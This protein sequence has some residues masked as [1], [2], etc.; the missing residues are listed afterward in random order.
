MF[1]FIDRTTA[2][3]IQNNHHNI[4]VEQLIIDLFMNNIEPI[5]SL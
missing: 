5:R 1:L 2:N 3:I 4:L